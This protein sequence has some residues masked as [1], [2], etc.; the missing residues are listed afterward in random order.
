MGDARQHGIVVHVREL[1]EH[2]CRRNQGDTQPQVLRGGPH[3]EARRHRT[4][5]QYGVHTEPE[6][7]ATGLVVTLTGDRRQDCNEETGNGQ[8]Q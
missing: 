7:A 6:D 3:E 1:A 5:Q 4:N 2:A 8:T